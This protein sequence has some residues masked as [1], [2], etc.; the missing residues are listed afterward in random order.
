MTPPRT[1]DEQLMLLKLAGNML[2]D[3]YSDNRWALHTQWVLHTQ[4]CVQQG[5]TP[6]QYPEMPEP[7]TESLLF[8]KAKTLENILFCDTVKSQPTS[9]AEGETSPEPVVQTSQ[10]ELTVVNEDEPAEQVESSSEDTAVTE[11][12]IEEE[13]LPTLSTDED[14]KDVQPID[15]LPIVAST[16]EPEGQPEP[17]PIQQGFTSNISNWLW[18]TKRT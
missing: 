3:Q 11:A 7:P 6:P 15:S 12:T 4:N 18:L 17:P 5:R 10:E 2:M 16:P 9:S 8:E 13:S 14:Q 1:L